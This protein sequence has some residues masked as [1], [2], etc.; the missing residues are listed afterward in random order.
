MRAIE[1]IYKMLMWQLLSVMLS[2]QVAW[3]LTPVEDRFLTKSLM[4]YFD[5]E[6]AEISVEAD[7]STQQKRAILED[8]ENDSKSA[9][10]LGSPEIKRANHYWTRKRGRETTTIYP[11][12]LYYPSYYPG[13]GSSYGY[14]RFRRDAEENNNNAAEQIG[15]EEEMIQTDQKDKSQ[16]KMSM[17]KQKPPKGQRGRKGGNKFERRF[18]PK[19]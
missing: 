11:Y 5:D 3:T 16:E 15:D 18:A 17:E 10:L 6:S 7:V 12:Q 4:N 13:Y 9:A 19:V 2:A 14:N 8:S 1:E